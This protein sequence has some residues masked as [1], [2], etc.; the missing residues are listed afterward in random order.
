[1]LLHF[2]SFSLFLLLFEYVEFDNI[3]WYQVLVEVFKV[4]IIFI[5]L[6]LSKPVFICIFAAFIEKQITDNY[7]YY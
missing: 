2:L 6:I 1:M 5:F 3:F 7:Q 4:L